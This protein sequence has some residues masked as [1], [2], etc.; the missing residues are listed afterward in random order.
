MAASVAKQD[1]G[2]A[3]VYH[4]KAGPDQVSLDRSSRKRHYSTRDKGEEKNATD[5][6]RKSRRIQKSPHHL[7]PQN[8]NVNA[9]IS[10]KS[11]RSQK[12][13][14][15]NP[16]RT[17]SGG[18]SRQS[19]RPAVIKR[20][21]SH[22]AQAGAG[23]EVDDSQH[24]RLA[25]QLRRSTP[26]HLEHSEEDLQEGLEP[27][28]EAG[29]REGVRPSI[30]TSRL[31]PPKDQLSEN[32]LRIFNAEMNPAADNAPVLKRTS[33]RR[34]IVPSE[35]G[36]VRSQR[37]SNTNA[38]YR[39]KNLQAV[40]IHI[41]AKPPDFIEAAANRIVNA[42]VS[43]QR[44]AE[45]R[46][47][48]QELSN[49]C[50]KNVKAQSGEDDFINPL[51]TALKALGLKNLCIHEKAEWRE[52][53]QPTAPQQLHFSSSFMAGVQQLEVDDDSARPIKRQQQSAGEYLSPE[54][55]RTNAPTTP[56][57]NNSQESNAMPPP[58]PPVLEKEGDRYPIK[59]PRPDLSI[60][61]DL[62]AFISA[63]SAQKLNR[64]KATAFIHWLQNEMVQR[65]P[66]G[67]LEPMLL[68]VPAPRALD[69]AFPFAVVEGKAYS[70]G[71]QIFEAENQAAVSGA[72]ALK[73][74]LD[75]DSL[76]NSGTMRSGALPKSS[77]AHP[78]LFFSITT[79]GP[80]HEL[81]YHW[82][83]YEDGVRK[84][85]SKLLD[86]CNAL[87]LERGEDFVVKLNNVGSW[88]T[89]PFVKSLVERLGQVA[90]KAET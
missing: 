53:L 41:H 84:F 39:H 20:K 66:K 57:A 3:Q 46:V 71:K 16:E 2:G 62:T 65:V 49:S 70:T 29:K 24:E 33:S 7:R 25:E 9:K 22:D 48:A 54:S 34:S 6:R 61:T 74:Q 77:N 88:G 31:P 58:A 26:P 79:Q 55:F 60:G 35:A 76:V 43:K 50:L 80:I 21:R 45:L 86:S 8:S 30:H 40:Q 81:W 52:E 69:L 37:S 89:G 23:A 83:V 1:T 38:F 12:T 51:H 11:P 78:P 68:L 14:A 27:E 36:T 72:C 44:R 42:K 82:T 67:P 47:I 13:Q 73:I 87:V 75:L 32:N 59:N 85:E 63:L 5:H 17:A 15:T 28:V 19:Q 18:Q 56:P 90:V 64:A 4:D 10:R